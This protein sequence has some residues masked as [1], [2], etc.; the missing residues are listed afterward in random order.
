MGK[1]V[2]DSSVLLGLLDAKDAHHEAASAAVRTCTEDGQALLLPA[3]ALSEILVGASRV[4]SDAVRVT[5]AFVNRIVTTVLPIDRA[6]ARSAAELRANYRNL[7]LPDALVLACGIVHAVDTVLTADRSWRRI[8]PRVR[9][10]GG[11]AR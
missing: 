6:V 10:I 3:T 11:P 7:R 5:E 1:V 8:D 2:L 4:G 9:V